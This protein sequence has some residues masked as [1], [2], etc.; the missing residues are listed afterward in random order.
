[1]MVMPTNITRKD[2]TA[3]TPTFAE[4]MVTKLQAEILAGSGGVRSTSIDGMTI[5]V[6]RRDLLKELTH[7]QKVVARQ[8]GTRPTALTIDLSNAATDID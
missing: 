8:K 6:S 5:N 4:Q 2:A 3:S 7:W 1:M